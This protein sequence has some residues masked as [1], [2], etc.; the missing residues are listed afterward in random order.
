M[1]YCFVFKYFLYIVVF[2]FIYFLSFY[3]PS[4]I[5]SLYNSFLNYFI[6]FCNLFFSY[7]NYHL[8]SAEIL[9][10]LCIFCL[11]QYTQ[12]MCTDGVYFSLLFMCSR[13][14]GRK[15]V[16]DLFLSKYWNILCATTPDNFCALCPPNFYF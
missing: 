3:F 8:A 4:F 5:F 11:R 12:S 2:L 1:L 6:L 13:E 10:G 16:V 15:T 7:T 9:P 14:F